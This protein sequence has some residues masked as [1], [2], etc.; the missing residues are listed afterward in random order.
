[1]WANVVTALGVTALIVR[2]LGLT[3][4]TL[5]VKLPGVA[6]GVPVKKTLTMPS[7]PTTVLPAAF[8]PLAVTVWFQ[9]TV[10]PGAAATFIG[11]TNAE[12]AK[13]KLR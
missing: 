11:I 8:T 1:L 3:T 5:T 9:V 6:V 12:I 7:A 13:T 2:P 10:N 4:V